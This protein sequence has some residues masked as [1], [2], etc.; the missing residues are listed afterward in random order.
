MSYHIAL[1][2]LYSLLYIVALVSIK[3]E[4]ISRLIII[5]SILAIAFI[6]SRFHILFRVD[7]RAE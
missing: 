5:D 1:L 6:A 3:G 7:N 2:L 4:Y